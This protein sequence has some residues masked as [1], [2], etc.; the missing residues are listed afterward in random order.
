MHVV[1]YSMYDYSNIVEVN[2]CTS[3]CLL[4]IIICVHLLINYKGCFR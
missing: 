2:T 4:I 1:T 3:S